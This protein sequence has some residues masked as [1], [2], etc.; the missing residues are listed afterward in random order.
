[1]KKILFLGSIMMMLLATCSTHESSKEDHKS[2]SNQNNV[3]KA[4]MPC[5][6]AQLIGVTCAAADDGRL[7][8]RRHL[9]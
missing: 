2:K 6:H 1:M 7:L 4:S 5:A 9:C 3:Q 8:R